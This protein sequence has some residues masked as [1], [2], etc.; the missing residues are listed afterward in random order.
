MMILKAA[1]VSKED[2]SA[3]PAN[4]ETRDRSGTDG[5]DQDTF[6]VVSGPDGTMNQEDSIW[7]ELRLLSPEGVT[8]ALT[9]RRFDF[10]NAIVLRVSIL[11]K[12]GMELEDIERPTALLRRSLKH[13]INNASASSRDH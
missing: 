1:F 11:E 4:R 3:G 10:K 9:T 2:N 12:S 13:S 8:L 7:P 6:G 5:I